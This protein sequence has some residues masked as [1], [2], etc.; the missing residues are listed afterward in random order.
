M[1]AFI[2]YLVLVILFVGAIYLV[3]NFLSRVRSDEK[4]LKLEEENEGLKSRLQAQDES[5]EEHRDRITSLIGKLRG[6][7]TRKDH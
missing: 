6:R 3:Y 7:E 4:M 5:I 2:K 1:D